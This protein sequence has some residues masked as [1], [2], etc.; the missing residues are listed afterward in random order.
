MRDIIKNIQLPIDGKPMDFRLT[1]LDA[2]SGATLLQLLARTE[3]NSPAPPAS[4]PERSEGSH[5][6]SSQPGIDSSLLTLFSTLPPADLRSLMTSCLNHVEVLLPAG[7]QPV[8]QGNSW[9]WPELEHD[10]ASCLKLTL[11]EALWTLSGFF[12]EGGPTSCP[13][14]PTSS[15]PPART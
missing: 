9:S 3:T 4:H 2:F 13:A 7:Y 5:P 12:G 11:E 6:Q 10:T 14:A 15:P 8:M 1:K